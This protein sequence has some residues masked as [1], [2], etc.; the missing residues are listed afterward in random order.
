MLYFSKINCLG[1]FN[2]NKK[3]CEEGLKTY[4]VLIRCLLTLKITGNLKKK[5]NTR[6]HLL[7][8]HIKQ[9]FP[10]EKKVL[11][12]KSKFKIPYREKKLSSILIVL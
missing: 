10:K 6:A 2:K 9:F 5:K 12:I 4:V 1:L 3:F 11:Y 8:C 7:F